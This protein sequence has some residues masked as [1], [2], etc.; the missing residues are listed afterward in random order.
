[1][2]N[3]THT[4]GPWGL[5]KKKPM[6]VCSAEGVIAD[7]DIDGARDRSQNEANARLIAA[8]PDL[9]EALTELV[10]QREGHYSTQTAWEIARAAIAKAKGGSDQ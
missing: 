3:H 7:C 5:I 1:M 9:L 10:V 6:F 2:T 8:A 4:S